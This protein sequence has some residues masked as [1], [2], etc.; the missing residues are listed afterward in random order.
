MRYHELKHLSHPPCRLLDTVDDVLEPLTGDAILS[1][2]NTRALL[3]T[4]AGFLATRIETSLR[5]HRFSPLGALALDKDIRAI[6]G[7]FAVGVTVLTR[8][9]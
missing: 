6:V 9:A 1:S 5:R 4:I 3:V 7:W 8:F 2:S